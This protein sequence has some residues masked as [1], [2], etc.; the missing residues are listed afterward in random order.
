MR[1]SVALTPRLLRERERHAIAVVDVLRATTSLVTMFERGL[2]RAIVAD[3]LRDAR[4]LALRNYSLLCGERESAPLPGFDYGNSPSEFSESSFRGKSAVLWTTNGTKAIGAAAGAPFVAAGA[5]VNRRAVAQ[6][7]VEE[8]RR[9]RID[10]AVVCAG[11]ER[12][13]AF[14]LEDSVAAGAIVEA[15]REAA[16]DI[17]LADSAWAAMHLWRWYR[18]DAMRAFRHSAHGRALTAGGFEQDLA[19]AAQVD[20]YDKVPLLFDEDGVKTM[21]LRPRRRNGATRA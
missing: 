3:T 7:L 18:G 9:R 13:L 11:L 12:G 16:D 8:A 4:N 6:R 21:R 20:L 10:V 2:I 19:F 17:E 15:A 14:S 5:L 1:I